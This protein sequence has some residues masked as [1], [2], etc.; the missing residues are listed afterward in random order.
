MICGSTFVNPLHRL[1]IINLFISGF[2]ADVTKRDYS[3]DQ[4]IH[5]SAQAG[6]TD[7]ITTLIFDYGCDPLARGFEERTLLH[8]TLAEGHTETASALIEMFQLSIHSVD[9]NGN[10]PLHLSAIKGQEESV[11]LLLYNYHA[12]VFVRNKAGQ[13][14][15]DHADTNI[16]L[17]IKHYTRSTRKSIQAEY[18]ELWSLSAQM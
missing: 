8:Q 10:T 18:Q 6:C 7:I 13:T 1:E 5:K 11:K 9:C 17:I 2:K 3:G 12:P 4:P 14:A 15:V 16:K